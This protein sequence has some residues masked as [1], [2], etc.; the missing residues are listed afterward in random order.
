MRKKIVIEF[1]FEEIQE[2][3]DYSYLELASIARTHSDLNAKELNNL[4]ETVAQSDRW[5][6]DIWMDVQRM[7]G[8][9]LDRK[10]I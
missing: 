5:Q 6:V 4:G 1:E 9:E 10:D 7:L 8:G 3:E 2:D